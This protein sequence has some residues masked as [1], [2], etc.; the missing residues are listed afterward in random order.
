MELAPL[1]IEVM[2]VEPGDHRGGSAK[3]RSRSALCSPC[4]ADNRE[5]AI[6]RIEADEAAGAFPK[7]LGNKVAKVMSLRKMPPRLRVAQTV[8]HIAAM[9]HDILPNRLF[10]RLLNLYYGIKPND[11][12]N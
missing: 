10:F 1:G 5:R 8:Q 2:L 4:Y 11:T 7:T 3:Y 12:K 9:L 6:E